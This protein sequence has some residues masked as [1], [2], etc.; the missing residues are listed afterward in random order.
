YTKGYKWVDNDGKLAGPA[1]V[2]LNL[3]VGGPWAGRFG[4]QDKLFPQQFT[5]DYVRVC[6]LTDAA[7]G[8]RTCGGSA[9]TPDPIKFAYTTGSAGHDVQRPTI[10]DAVIDTP[11]ARAGSFIG[12]K[13]RIDASVS[14]DD[15][16]ALYVYLVN[17]K[18]ESVGWQRVEL[19]TPTTKWGGRTVEVDTRL[20]LPEWVEPGSYGVYVAIGSP[21][22]WDAEGKNS[23]RT[24]NLRYAPG[25]KHRKR[26]GQP[27]RWKV[28][29]L[30]IVR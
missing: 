29:E 26:I 19:P 24:L 3:A 5:I 21:E 14:T 8:S 6:Q 16:H 25:A 10:H 23:L 2:L 27:T 1:H 4:I 18:R 28:G 9:V 11:S 13:Q 15:K 22:E 30:Q 12:F 17:A 7:N 20:Q